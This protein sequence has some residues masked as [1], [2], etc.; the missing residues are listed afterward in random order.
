MRNGKSPMKNTVTLADVAQ[1]CGLSISSVSLVLN[2]KPLADQMAEKTR[3]RIRAAALRLGYRPNRN[4]QALRSNRSNTIGVMVFDVADPWCTLILKGIQS[5]LDTTGML[6]IIMDAQNQGKQFMR[7]LTLLM[8]RRVEALIVVANWL[9]ADAAIIDEL[10]AIDIPIVIVG[11]DFKSRSLSCFLV[12]NELGGYLALQHLYEAGHRDIAVI[13]GPH[14]LGDSKWR[15]KGVQ[16]FAAFAGFTLDRRL[17]LQMAD[18]GDPMAGFDGGYA[19]TNAL[20]DAG[21]RFSAVLAF[22]DV[23]ALGA[24][25]ALHEHGMPVPGEVS[26]IGFDDIPAAS[27]TSPSLS[28]VRQKM[29]EMGTLAAE[30]VLSLIEADGSDRQGVTRLIEPVIVSRDS[31]AQPR[32]SRGLSR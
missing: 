22:D 3:Q 13:R 8:E 4:A 15:W 24:I 5:A 29:S 6:P 21:R 1:E 23:T 18:V 19:A 26:V 16:K 14:G 30:H 7:Y 28:T 12:D 32:S 17:V 27:L 2:E 25:R 31:T 9:L 11:K 10:E 20:L